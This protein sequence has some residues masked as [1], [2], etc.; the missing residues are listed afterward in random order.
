MAVTEGQFDLNA[1]NTFAFA[2]NL[3]RFLNYPTDMRGLECIGRI[4][5]FVSLPLGEGLG[6]GV[7]R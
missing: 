6:M 1:V 2:L 7:R 3:L 4:F 5:N